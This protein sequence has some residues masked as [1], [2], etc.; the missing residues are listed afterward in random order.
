[1]RIFGGNIPRV[2]AIHVQMRAISSFA[3]ALVAIAGGMCG[4]SPRPKVPEKYRMVFEA[5]AE[6]ADSAFAR[7]GPSDQVDAFVFGVTY[8][9]PGRI[10]LAEEL[11]GSGN[12]VVPYV[13]ARLKSE[14]REFVRWQLLS[15]IA[16]IRCTSGVKLADEERVVSTVREVVASMNDAYSTE[17]KAAA[18]E[19][20]GQCKEHASQPTGP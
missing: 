17:A 16:M 13:L 6:A 15:V 11:A 5:P 9:F 14:H 20:E 12:A 19:I 4:C 3:A 18:S 1:V 7:L 8:F 2:V 10:G